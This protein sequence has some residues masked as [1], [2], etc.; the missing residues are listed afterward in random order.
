MKQPIVTTKLGKVRGYE[1]NGVS[2]FKGIPYA[3]AERFHSPHPPKAWDSVLDAT[4]YG[5]VCPVSLHSKPKGELTVPHRYWV[6]NEDCL[7]LNIWTP[8]CDDH[9]RP[10]LVWLHGGGY[11]AGSA[12]EQP[13]Y[14][15]DSLCR[16]GQIVVVSVNH[17]LNVLGYCD[18]SGYGAEYENSANAGT[19]DLVAAL[20]WIRE[21]IEVFGGDPGSVTLMGQSGGGAKVSVLLQTPAA[22]G[23]FHRGINMSGVLGPVLADAKG[24][25][26][27]LAE[28]LMKELNV[29][30]VKEL[31]KVPAE[32]LVD[33]YY[34]IRPALEKAGKYAGSRPKK[35][36]FYLGMPDVNP[37]CAGTNQ[38]PMLIGSVFGEFGASSAAGFDK[39]SLSYE[40][41]RRMVTA[42]LGEDTAAE[43]LPL[44]A[45]AYP[46]RNPVDALV[47][48][49]I[50]RLPTKALIRQRSAMN[51]CTWSYLFNMDMPLDGGRA[52]WHCSDIPF[53]FH[54][55]DLAPVARNAEH[56]KL[57]EKQVSESIIAFVKTGNPNNPSIP[58]WPC[59]TETVDNTMT[60]DENTHL[61]ANH[62]AKLM[63]CMMKNY[64]FIIA[65]MMKN[66]GSVQH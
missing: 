15:G 45:E 22:Q 40:D 66:L 33:A 47:L 23:L 6:M 65:R 39:S 57:V 50:F 49:C 16:L 3:E 43:L 27:E 62:D 61:R 13:A 58:E 63:A 60:F 51:R 52:P 9:K 38:I 21:N 25:G 44:F 30:T 42:A 26:R 11:E 17:R 41:G 20:Q 5:F 4:S 35:N 54:N 36:A 28:T 1:D 34:R 32:M 14:E 29:Q 59:S 12:I 37:P 46:E 56:A 53:A 8:S 10:V 48:D 31:E 19:E 2:V 18:L 55:T 64:K 24:D 7:N